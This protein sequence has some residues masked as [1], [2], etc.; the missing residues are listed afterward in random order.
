ME[1]KRRRRVALV[2]SVAAFGGLPSPGAEAAFVTRAEG[3][4]QQCPSH[5]CEP[6]EPAY[7]LVFRAE[8]GETNRLVAKP[9]P[10]PAEVTVQDNGAMLGAGPGCTRISGHEAVCDVILE[11]GGNV[12]L[13]DGPDSAQLPYPIA[14]EGGP[15]DDQIWASRV[16][17]G[18][19]DDLVEGTDNPDTLG[20]GGGRDV[21]R[22]G[23]ASDSLNDGDTG[24]E[25]GPDTLDGGLGRDTISYS[26]RKWPVRVDLAQAS[27]GQP[28]EDDRLIDIE[29]AI[30]GDADDFLVA[31]T[32][33]SFLFGGSGDDRV[34]GGPGRDDLGGG[35][36][37]DR[38]GGAAGR[39]SL[40]GGPGADRL[41]A[42]AGDDSAIGDDLF[43]LRGE[44]PPSPGRDSVDGG[45]GNDT[46]KGGGGHDRMLGGPGND[47]VF[48]S[49]RKYSPIKADG[50][51]HLDGGPGNDL[52]SGYL[53]SDVLR[54]GL[55]SDRLLAGPGNDLLL[56]RDQ[57]PDFLDG[58]NGRDRTRRD[59]RIDR[60]RNVERFLGPRPAR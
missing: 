59:P 20:G 1:R 25:P 22:G 11:L 19:G 53:G 52:L 48:G 34:V 49:D 17:A 28:G 40:A 29:G 4:E 10:G 51:D 57:R 46:L 35:E 8:P 38:L 42:G 44:G 27:G 23:K 30:G 26:G 24:P 6:S 36:G 14:V 50:S 45:A 58:G 37:D 15:G 32:G 12:S 33:G 54:G 9:G 56:S 2:A 13:G 47:L 43:T 16:Q 41:A 39:D 55:G 3:P 21:L 31:L 5:G 18:P 7:M 60:A